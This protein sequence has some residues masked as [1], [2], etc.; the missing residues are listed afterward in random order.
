MQT[1]LRVILT[2]AVAAIA[3]PAPAAAWDYPG[4]RLV[5]AVA[6]LVLQQYYPNTN[7]KIAA[8][9][10][11]TDAAGVVV[12]RSLSQVAVFP[13][14]AKKGNE[15]FCGR[16]PS[17]EE[18]A[19][20]A[21]NKHNDSFHFTDLPLQQSS[22]RPGSAG[23]S[24][25]DVVHMINFAVAQLRA[26]TA[27][28]KP[29]QIPGEV[30]LTDT[31]AVW[32]LTH[33]VGDIHQ[34]LHVGANY[35]DLSCEN[36]VDPN[37]AGDAKDHFGIGK[38]VAT[39]VG[40][41]LIFIEPP[42]PAVPP[43][44]N[45]HLYWD[46]TTVVRAMRAA[47]VAQS[48]PDFAKLLAAAPPDGWETSGAP[49]TWAAQWATEIMPLAVAAHERLTIRKGQRPPPFSGTGGCNWTTTLDPAYE[50]WASERARVQLAKAGFR[51]AALL[52]AIFEPQ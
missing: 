14:C 45:L 22:Y 29:K 31:E 28:D 9:L 3:V 43:M 44:P 38:T 5:G 7:A 26:K 47:G 30:D 11:K 10:Q 39:T 35:T 6:D 27:A 2:A 1:M 20:T 46:A 52:A 12:Q 19:Y 49:E 41:N 36:S 32:L 40:G 21:R 51:L 16:P 15:P 42:K 17:D 4:H 8:L 24:D 48:E 34:P 37:Q 18:K 33:L 13:D 23:T 50:D 25:I